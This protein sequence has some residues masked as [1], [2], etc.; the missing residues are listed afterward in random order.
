[1]N[2]HRPQQPPMPACR[3]LFGEIEVSGIPLPSSLG[4]EVIEIQVMPEFDSPY[5]K[6]GEWITKWT[7]TDADVGSGIELITGLVPADAAYYSV[8]FV[9]VNRGKFRTAS[10][11]C[12]HIH[13]NGA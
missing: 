11:P 9:A 2:K 8:R 12:P 6:A 4:A 10:E 3:G 13:T 7:K 5:G 1:M